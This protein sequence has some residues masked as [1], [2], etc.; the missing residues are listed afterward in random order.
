MMITTA[1]VL[2]ALLSA[3]QVEQ[4]S[5]LPSVP[6]LTAAETRALATITEN[7]VKATV[8][9]LAS[10]ELL[11]RDTPSPG[12]WIAGAYVAARLRG[13]GLEGLGDAGSF[14]QT[15]HVTVQSVPQTAITLTD[16]Q[17]KTLRQLGM[18]QAGSAVEYEGPAKPASEAEPGDVVAVDFDD[19][20]IGLPESLP[21]AQRVAFSGRRALRRLARAVNSPKLVLLRVARDSVLVD[22]ARDYA[23]RPAMVRSR[24]GRRVA[25]PVLLVASGTDLGNIRVRV[26]ATKSKKE[27]VRNTIGILRGRDPEL[28]KQA[29][30][31]SAHLDH[32]GGRV[33][34]GADGIN[35]GADDDASGVTAVLALADAFAALPERPKRS[36][37]FMTFWGEEKG[38]LGSRYFCEHPTWPLAQIVAD[39]NLEMVGRPEQNARNKAWMT[40]WTYSNLGELMAIGAKRVGTV[41]FRHKQYSRQ[42]Y[43]QSDNWSFAAKGVI[44]HSLSAG[45]LHSDYHRPSDEWQKL[46]LPH[47]TKVIRGLFAGSLPLAEGLLTPVALQQPRRRRR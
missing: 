2:S 47:M 14:H 27:P 6:E 17:G 5:Q 39:I 32:I 31:I 40:G 4:R 18:I 16:A 1:L 36:V 25:Y 44:A 7:K 21:H 29:I 8:S 30:V 3:Q 19:E 26:P 11:G 15:T 13:A 24:R 46:D 33:L 23:G 43:A 35:N 28:E 45:S 42:L 9:F 22:Y 34:E 10:D 12:L 20:A 38:L 41:I 37:I